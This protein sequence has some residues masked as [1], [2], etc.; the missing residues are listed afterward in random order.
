MVATAQRYSELHPGVEIRWE[1]RSLQDFAD[2][3]I[4][5]LA[6]RYD[7]MVIDHPAIGESA[8]ARL[9]VA[10]DEVLPAEFLDDQAQHSVGLSHSS[11]RWR[12]HQWALA[13]DAA[14][15]VSA[16]RVD[17][18]ARLGHT[19]PECW[20]EVVELGR[21][22]VVA[23]AGLKLDSLM[24]WYTLCINEG[25]EPFREEARLVDPE[26]GIG[27]LNALKEL[28]DACGPACLTRNPI[29]AYELLAG[30]SGYAYSPI[31]YG[32]SNYARPAYV[33]HPLRFGALVNRNDTKLTSTLGGA[34]LA[35]SSSTRWRSQ[36]V[37][38]ARFVASEE[39]QSG[40]YTASGGQP[41]HRSAWVDDESNRI[42]G[43]FFAET[44]D[45]LDAAYMRPRYPGYID[46]QTAASDAM[47]QFLRGELD[48]RTTMSRFEILD[49][50]H[51][52]GR[53]AEFDQGAAR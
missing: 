45:T 9:F 46:F 3:S 16:S 8:S 18:L 39:I 20:E 48:S 10:L 19:V 6:A 41:G 23:F 5:G 26:A 2:Q 27:A 47:H 28:T 17:V 43:R 12:G 38:Y 25:D 40:L 37:D 1:T 30:D 29:A 33:A 50:H 15:P 21:R 7:L 11:Y 35:V 32:Y 22:G 14:T 31:A 52:K 24:H 13:I 49:R 36:A 44:L 42:T 53:T 34:G 51:R 4:S